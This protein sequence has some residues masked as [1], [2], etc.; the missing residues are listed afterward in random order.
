MNNIITYSLHPR[1][2]NYM[3]MDTDCN[4]GE[5]TFS[6]SA[7]FAHKPLPSSVKRT[8]RHGSNNAFTK[9]I[10][11]CTWKNLKYKYTDIQ[12]SPTV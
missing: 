10:Q 2:S 5:V 1:Y 9:L 12:I 7:N 6:P 4:S 3:Y 11:I 8:N